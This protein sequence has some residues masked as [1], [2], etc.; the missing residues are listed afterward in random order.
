MPPLL[1]HRI[2]HLLAPKM[3]KPS[4]PI[5]L[6]TLW[7]VQNPNTPLWPLKKTYFFATPQKML[8]FRNFQKSRVFGGPEGGVLVSKHPKLFSISIFINLVG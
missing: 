7:R 5:Y 8:K 6:R 2:R 1:F 4:S 3:I